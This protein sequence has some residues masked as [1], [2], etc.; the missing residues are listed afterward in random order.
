[1][2]CVT[3]CHGGYSG[4]CV[5]TQGLGV[6]E[7]AYRRKQFLKGQLEGKKGAGGKKCIR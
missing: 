1:M 6:T 5:S 2:Q 4:S 3:C 7:K